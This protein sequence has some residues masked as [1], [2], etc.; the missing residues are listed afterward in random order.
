ML[1]STA[2]A[3]NDPCCWSSASPISSELSK[4]LPLWIIITVNGT[5]E[6]STTCLLF[7]KKTDTLAIHNISPTWKCIIQ[8]IIH[9]RRYIKQIIAIESCMITIIVYNLENLHNNQWNVNSVSYYTSYQ[10]RWTTSPLPTFR[11]TALENPHWRENSQFLQG[12]S[13][14]HPWYGVNVSC[15]GMGNEIYMAST[16]LFFVFLSLLPLLFCWWCLLV[17]VLNEEDEEHCNQNGHGLIIITTLVFHVQFND[18]E[19]YLASCSPSYEQ[20]LNN[21]HL[22]CTGGTG[23]QSFHLWRGHHR[24][25]TF[26]CRNVKWCPLVVIAAIWTLPC[27]QLFHLSQLWRKCTSQFNIQRHRNLSFCFTWRI[28]VWDVIGVVSIAC[29]MVQIIH[30]YP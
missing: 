3:W 6:Y 27:H 20:D 28:F 19:I 30:V 24:V 7:F 1:P 12:A 25:P 16:F 13:L 26:R 23:S 9:R 17:F 18:L 21:L 4:R 29:C 10:K 11:V 2:S 22:T 5:L 15:Y 8:S 14:W